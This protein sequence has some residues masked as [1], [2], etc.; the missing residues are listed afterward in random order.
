MGVPAMNGLKMLLYQGILA[1]ELWNDLTVEEPL[2]KQVYAALQKAVYG[3]GNPKNNLVLTGFMGAGKTTLGKALAQKLGYSFVD[4]DDYIVQREGM[5]IPEIFA[6][7]GEDYFRALETTVLQELKEKLHCAVVA[8]GG[9]LPLREENGRLLMEIGT[10]YYL[11]A[12][13]DTIYERVKGCTNRPLLQCDD[14]YGRICELMDV[15]NPIYEKQCHVVIETD[16]KTMDN[17][18]GQIL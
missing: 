8:T 5:T 10:V 1:Y 17:L 16:G 15:R 14:P 2:V 6:D 9:G 12:S 18:L 13:A 4:T 7:K 3:T 11:K